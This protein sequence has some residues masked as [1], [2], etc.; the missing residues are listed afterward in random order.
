MSI[1]ANQFTKLCQ[2]LARID[3]FGQGPPAPPWQGHF[4]EAAVRRAIDTGTAGLPLVFWSGYVAPLEQ[5]LGGVMGLVTVGR[6]PASLVESLAGAVYQHAPGSVVQPELQRFLA[7]VSNFYRSFLSATQRA[8]LNLPLIEQLPPLAMFQHDGND[9]PFT[10]PAD[11]VAQL[12]GARLGVVSLPSTYREHPLLW[13]S[14]AHETAGHDVL[15]ADP[16]LLD[17][18]AAGVRR[19][20]GGGPIRSGR[21]PTVAQLN[22]ALWA[23]WMDEAASDVYGL[24]N[25]GPEFALNLA[26]FFAAMNAR[27]D[28]GAVPALR[29]QSGQNGEGDPSLDVHPTD[30][31]RLHLAIGVVEQLAG[32]AATTRAQYVAALK[33]L[34]VQCGQ[35][36]TTIELQGD[37]EISAGHWLSVNASLPLAPMQ[38]AARRAGGF[39]A[40]AKLRALG[41]HGIQEIETWDDTDE[42]AAQTIAE[43]LRNDAPVVDRGDDAQLLAGATLALL[44]QPQQYDRVT[45]RLA[46]ALDRS[47]ALDPI[48]GTPQPDHAYVRT[49][50]LD[51]ASLALRYYVGVEGGLA[52]ERDAKIPATSRKGTVQRRPQKVAA[53]Q[54]EAPK[55][56]MKPVGVGNHH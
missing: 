52:R 22:G 11:S 14:L 23:Y 50:F 20:F 42:H 44:D 37:L 36:A 2:I 47:F 26:A 48:W 25:I 56:Q 35:G 16:G 27:I 12:C 30:L 15:H 39:I 3:L 28:G 10:L 41:G 46:A 9:G 40:T 31:L 51:P 43:L 19:M 24:L 21:K 34:A 55:R 32:L 38:E 5:H 4:T 49:R 1:Q 13:A 54:L 8:N 29:T 33:G 45:A 18:L 17:E 6:L 7:V 53:L